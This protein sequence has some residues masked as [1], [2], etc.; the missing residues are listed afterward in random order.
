MTEITQIYGISQIGCL[1]YL[2]SLTVLDI[3]SKR[4]PIW[5]LG[6]GGAVAVVFQLFWQQEP[7][8]LIAAGGAVGIVFLAV[9]KVTEEAFGYGDS[10][11]IGI[12]GIYLGFWNLL[13]LLVVTFLLAAGAAM[14][15]LIKQRFHRKTVLPFVP[16]LETGYLII[17][18][19]GGF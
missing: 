4:L 14:A 11:L 15:V 13:N 12:L 3:R 17:V 9:S 6:I 18:L 7:F 2:G 19:L 5:M 16:F 10:V 1:F 8:I